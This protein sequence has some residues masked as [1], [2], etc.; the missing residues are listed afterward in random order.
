MRV[1]ITASKNFILVLTIVAVAKLLNLRFKM[2]SL[3]KNSCTIG[4]QKTKFSK[5]RC[6]IGLYNNVVAWLIT[7]TGVSIKYTFTMCHTLRIKHA[8]IKFVTYRITVT[9]S[10]GRTRLDIIKCLN[11]AIALWIKGDFAVGF[12]G[13]VQL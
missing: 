8:P 5:Q 11:V 4:R 6:R 10:K 7:V 9:N 2:N 1:Y 13:V 12:G 3:T